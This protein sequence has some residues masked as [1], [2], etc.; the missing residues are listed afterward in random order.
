MNNIK[1][2]KCVCP[3]CGKEGPHYVPPSLGEEGFFICDPSKVI[4]DKEALMTNQEAETINRKFA[5]LCDL[6]WHEQVSTKE[7]GYGCSCGYLTYFGGEYG[8][9]IK[10]NPSPD[11][12]AN[13]RLVLR[14]MRKTPRYH[15]FLRSLYVEAATIEE[16]LDR[17]LVQ[18]ILDTTE[19][20]LAKAGISYLE[21]G[22][23]NEEEKTMQ[24]TVF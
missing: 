22:R 5:E 3:N 1:K 19:G 15:L 4:Q 11:F 24:K 6:G 10:D 16:M 9:H 17:S 12:V 2:E 23:G 18:Y 13:S 8:K 14:E 21:K 20:L 7:D